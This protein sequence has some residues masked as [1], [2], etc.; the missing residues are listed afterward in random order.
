VIA[1]SRDSVPELSQFAREH[2]LDFL[3]LSDPD[4]VYCDAFGLRHVRASDGHGGDLARPAVLFF[5]SHGRL[6]DCFL[7]DDWRERLRGDEALARTRAMH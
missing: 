6:A 4:L 7:P 5:D 1:I 3:L 2:G